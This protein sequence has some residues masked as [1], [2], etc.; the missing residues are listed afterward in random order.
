L[1]EPLPPL[2]IDAGRS[3]MRMLPRPIA[4]PLRMRWRAWLATRN[5]IAPEPATPPA[6]HDELPQLRETLASIGATGI[7]KADLNELLH[8]LRGQALAELPRGAGHFVSVG[9]SGKWYFD[10]IAD[11]C[12]PQFHTGIEF[13][14]PKPDGLPPNTEWIANTAGN[15]EGVPD[16]SADILFSGQNIEHLWCDDVANFLLES[17]RVLKPGGLLVADSPNRRITAR[18]NWSQPEHTIEFDADEARELLTLAGFDVTREIG[19]WLCE[20]D[21]GDL[22]PLTELT[23]KGAWPLRRRVLEAQGEVD[24]SFIWWL[25]ARRSQRAPDEA[26]LRRRIEEINAVAWPERLNRLLT[27][28]GKPVE[29]NGGTW[30]DSEGRGGV[31]VY[32]P[33]TA[34]PAGHHVLTMTVEFPD[35]VAAG[36]EPATVH[37][38]GGTQDQIVART[39]MPPAPAGQSVD[40]RVAFDLP[41][42][43][44]QMQFVVV[45]PAGARM[46]ARKAVK[47][48]S[49][50]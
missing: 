17:H 35:G 47:L 41:D 38:S 13:Y 14:S 19:I 43:T 46:L 30:F 26:A 31:L 45:A 18:L 10:W 50:P 5:A 21:R 11:K 23:T 25:E 2:I 22:L 27:Q 28:I 36:A 15:M 29:R 24:R 4:Q 37:V 7:E 3:L 9:C 12:A 1:R 48:R 32:G 49:S 8:F 44:F 40:V 16:A 42:T 6:P 39:E 34:L 20:T 33:Y